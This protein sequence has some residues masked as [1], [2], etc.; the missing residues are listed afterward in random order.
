M[1]LL[2]QQSI[3]NTQL[4]TGESPL[5]AA[6]NTDDDEDYREEKREI[7]KL[8]EAAQSGGLQWSNLYICIFYDMQSYNLSVPAY[9]TKSDKNVQVEGD[10]GPKDREWD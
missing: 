1:L 2:Q 10:G 7:V 4:C 3:D 5:E 9:Q 8:L 6:K